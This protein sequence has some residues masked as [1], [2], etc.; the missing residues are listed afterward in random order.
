MQPGIGAPYGPGPITPRND[1]LAVTALVLAI[2]SFVVC[3]IVG[4]VAALVVAGT[5]ASRIRNNP[6]QLG[7]L[8]MV[9]AARVLAAINLVLSVL[10]LLG[11]A[12]LL[13]IGSNMSRSG[14]GIVS[15]S[16]GVAEFVITPEARPVPAQ[17]PGGAP[18]QC[19][20]AD[21]S[22]PQTQ[23]FAEPFDMCIDAS[24]TYIATVVTDVGRFEIQLDPAA[25]PL[26]VNNFV[27]LAR[28]HFYDGV[29]FHRAVPGFVV[30]GGDPT[31]TGGGGPGYQFVDELPP[32][33][34]TYDIGTVAMA[35]SGPHTNGSQ[36]FVV[37]GER[38][39]SLAV[40]HTVF[41]RVTSGIEVLQQIAAD[42]ANDP[43]PP[44]I[45][46]R[47]QSVTITER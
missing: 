19:P 5:A 1:G 47:M 43:S 11:A 27:S 15:S 10:A 31:G 30:Q 46:H 18:A 24:K 36:F 40:E 39:R 3:P 35:N 23:S 2:L 29:A 4:A 34:A 32:D 42:G 7:G 28:H 21:G 12:V 33:G 45:V 38:G 17:P 8:G 20:P 16:G 44:R 25:A 14:G 41:G 37:V 9:S 13:S 6:W 26:A 22:A